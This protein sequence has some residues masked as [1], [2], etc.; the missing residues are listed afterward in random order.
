MRGETSITK[1]YCDFERSA[2][3]AHRGA[4][5]YKMTAKSGGTTYVFLTDDIAGG[6]L[7]GFLPGDTVEMVAWVYVPTDGGPSDLTEISMNYR[8]DGVNVAAANP[9]VY[10]QWEKL[11]FRVVMPDSAGMMQVGFYNAGADG[12]YFYVDDIEVYRLPTFTLARE[13]NLIDRGNCESATLPG[14]LGETGKVSGS[15][16][17][18][19]A[20]SSEQKRSGDYSIRFETDGLATRRFLVVDNEA[21]TD[22]HGI[23]PGESVETECW[24]YVPSSGGPSVSEVVSRVS[25]YD[26]GAWTSTDSGAVVSTDT[27]TKMTVSVTVPSTATGWTYTAA[28]IASTASEGEYI[29]VDDIIVRRHSV[30]G[31]HYL[32]GGYTEHLVEL[33][34][35]FTLQIKFKP[36]F[37]YDVGSNQHLAGCKKDSTREF[38]VTYD[39]VPDKFKVVWEDGGTQ[40]FLQSLRYDDGSSHRNINQWLT[41]TVAVDTTTGSS[42]GSSLWMDKAQDDTSWSGTIDSMTTKFNFLRIRTMDGGD[43]GNCDIAFVRFFPDF[44]ATDA[45]V[46][47][48]FKDVENEEVYWSFDGHAT[49]ETRCHILS[50]LIGGISTERGVVNRMS[51]ASSA[52][53]LAAAL[54]NLNGEFSDDQN[55]AFDAP[56]RV[57]NGT[58][59]QNYLRRKC[60]VRLEDWYSGD[61]DNVFVGR[62]STGFV[63]SS[64]NKNFSTVNIGAFDNVQRMNHARVGGPGVLEDCVLSGSTESNSLMHLLPRLALQGQIKQYLAN[65]SFED[66]SLAD[67]WDS[68]D[69]ETTLSQQADP[70]FGAKCGQIAASGGEGNI[71][72][73]VTFTGDEQ[74][75]VG[76]TFT[77]YCWMKSAAEVSKSNGIQLEERDASGQNAETKADISLQGEDEFVLHSST[78]TVTDSDSDRLRVLITIDDETTLKVD[79]CMLVEGDEVLGWFAPSSYV[80]DN[81]AASGSVS[82]DKATVSHYDAMGFDVEAVTYT[83]PWKR[84]DQ[85]SSVWQHISSVAEGVAPMYRGI[86]ENGTFRLRAVLRDSYSDPV[87]M[88]N[89]V[90]TDIE[91]GISTNLTM[92]KANRLEGHGSRIVKD[93]YVRNLW[94]ATESGAFQKDN[95]GLL[96]QRVNDGETWPDRDLVP[97]FATYRGVSHSPRAAE[98]ADPNDDPSDDPSWFQNVWSAWK[99]VGR[100]LLGRG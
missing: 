41:L 14:I 17:A 48:D 28:R 18:S 79:G 87:P 57:Y 45:Q 11:T 38:R 47:N 2:E 13:D 55:A 51:G 8:Y 96:S 16:G 32:S 78:H 40:R 21:T 83:H 46:Q 7:H 44:V 15:G 71:K 74:L 4:Y 97:F 91:P 99:D 89:F 24:V 68:N 81:A 22:L 82:A 94:K 52:N 100:F 9:T 37:A 36:N 53:T 60:R 65:N 61:F 30:P 26:G 88:H 77:F 27:W 29:Y 63:R 3:Q 6:N 20:R 84:L 69:T 98:E 25:Y 56:N 58:A 34:S 31:T 33:P 73:I 90:E 80:Q 10:D 49:G 95:L 54:L 75:S 50:D 12:E 5:S 23:V 43:L 62:L 92:R 70:L 85:G 64:L 19:A 93:E 72:Q 66:A 86:D 76:R 67:A 59:A 1:A 35:K 39:T 42:S